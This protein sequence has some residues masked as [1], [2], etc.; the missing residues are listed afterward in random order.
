[1]Q[2]AP[3]F[4]MASAPRAPVYVPGVTSRA[5]DS[6]SPISAARAPVYV[7]GVRKY[8]GGSVALRHAGSPSVFSRHTGSPNLTGIVSSVPAR[9]AASPITAPWS[10]TN[11][12]APTPVAAVRG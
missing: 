4:D 11:T 1:M 8:T 7:P 2:I 9:P 6:P 10:P 3:L 12:A 5:T